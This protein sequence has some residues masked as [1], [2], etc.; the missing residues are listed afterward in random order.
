MLQVIREVGIFIVIAQAVL[1]FVP[2]ESYVKYV[3]II[4]GIIM[5][6]KMAQPV[7]LLV[8]GQEWQRILEEMPDFQSFSGMEILETQ[9]G[10]GRLEENVEKELLKRLNAEPAEGYEIRSA[11]FLDTAGQEGLELMITVSDRR[12]KD[13]AI[14]IEKITVGEA[15]PEGGQEK[16]LAEH[17]GQVLGIEP[18]R[19][20]VKME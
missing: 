15:A 10:A 3:K 1:Y 2:G 17:Y 4:I 20:R 8:N 11:G 19:I 7:L 9:E 16:E 14:R 12:E 5:I 18:D 13:S 6:A